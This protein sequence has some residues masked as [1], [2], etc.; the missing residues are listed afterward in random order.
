MKQ[1][2]HLSIKHKFNLTFNGEPELKVKEVTPGK[3][4]GLIPDIYPFIKPKVIVSIGDT[5][6][7][8]QAI[9]FDKKNPQVYFHSP[10]SGVVKNIVYGYQRK[11]ELIEFEATNDE[12]L[13]FTPVD[14][15][16][17]STTLLKS[18][19]LERGLW[20]HFRE[21]PF[22][23][24]PS[25]DDT[26]PAIFVALS[27]N[28]PFQ[29]KL[30][31]VFD[32]YESSIIIALKFLMKLTKHVVPFS[33][34]DEKINLDSI[35]EVI[36]ITRVS[37]Q[38]PSLDPGAVVY[39]KKDSIE[40]NKSWYCDWHFLIKL[41]KSLE[42]NQ[43]YNKQ[44]ISV[45]GNND[46]M[47][48]H[49]LIEEGTQI[50]QIVNIPDSSTDRIIFGGLFTGIHNYSAEF[51]PMG[52]NAL[53]IIDNDPQ[54]EFLSFLQPGFTKPS[55]TTA[56][57]SGF[58]NKFN[59]TPTSTSVNGSYRDCVSCGHCLEVCPVDSIPQTILRNIEGDDIEEAVRLGLLDCS[60]CG[61]CTYVCPSKIDLGSI[62]TE[63]K[64]SLYK[65]LKA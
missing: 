21:L 37:G 40:L 23:N 53:N 30:S 32:K 38:Y 52:T 25:P 28:E 54:P 41:G 16:T 39:H 17:A 55:Y 34:A 6:K 5:V 46:D 4:F 18:T 12:P 1:I 59:P 60:G 42:N 27:N 48:H 24:I 19:L 36:P 8:G 51:M 58:L 11:L 43:Y 61:V 9:F 31:T 49:Y 62:F 15:E 10:R 65:E 2:Q 13:Q 50:N 33:D 35:N 63:A 20:N 56:Y 44:V 64:N 29:P 26:P 7:K 45:G 22:K 14:I 3:N 57:L 47:N